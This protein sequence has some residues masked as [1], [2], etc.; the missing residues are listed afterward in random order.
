MLG[1]KSL[2]AVI[3]D[4]DHTLIKS[5]IDFSAMKMR[6]VN[7]L[8]AEYPAF[9]ELD[10][11]WTTY[12]IV[13]YTA[14]YLEKQGTPE[15][16]PRVTCELNRI[17]VDIEMT[18]VSK[19]TLIDGAVEALNTLRNAGLKRA[20]LTRSCRKYAEE[21]LK[22]TGLSIFV[23]EVAPRD[24]CENPKPNPSQVY[25]LLNRMKVSSNAVVMV[26]DH[27]TD[28]LCA[29]NAGIE[30][31]GVL[32]GSWGLEQTKKLGPLTVASVK[33]LPDLLGL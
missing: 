32:T 24:D 5:Q 14:Q 13:G 15:A 22:T 2:G 25:W 23:D 10:N 11:K 28:A 7:Y 8:R 6:M 30:F 21:V 3:F 1:L 29:K 20:I 18:S 31:I 16:V 17:M 27:P 4:L 33:E 9:S 19:A 26:G 12:E